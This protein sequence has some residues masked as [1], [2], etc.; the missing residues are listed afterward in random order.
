MAHYIHYINGNLGVSIQDLDCSE[1]WGKALF[2][3]KLSGG[4][5]KLGYWNI[6]GAAASVRY[7]LAYQKT[8]YDTKY[9]KTRDEWFNEK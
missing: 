3:S 5:P 6:R 7:Q 4:K 9:Y 8:E 2:A 1:V